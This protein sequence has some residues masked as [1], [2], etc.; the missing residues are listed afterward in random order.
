MKTFV[1]LPT[2]NEAQNLGPMIE[3]LLALP[4]TDIHVLVI[5]DN[6]QDGTGQIA[7]QLSIQDPNRVSVLH[8]PG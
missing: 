4:L 8:R 7:D 3:R 6:S 5:D 1:I 2:Y